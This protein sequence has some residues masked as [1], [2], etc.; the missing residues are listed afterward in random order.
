MVQAFQHVATGQQ[1]AGTVQGTGSGGQSGWGGQRQGTGTGGHQQGENDPEGAV[2]VDLP[3]HQANQRG[4]DQHCNEEPLCDAIGQFGQAR[5]LALRAL[6]QADD[7][8]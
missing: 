8:G 5:F 1:Q 2:T 3:P 4:D 6:Q 7:G